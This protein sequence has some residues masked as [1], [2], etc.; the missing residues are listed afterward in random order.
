MIK[1][2][3]ASNGEVSPR[4][5][6]ARGNVCL[7]ATATHTEASWCRVSEDVLTFLQL[8]SVLKT[9][10]FKKCFPQDPRSFFWEQGTDYKLKHNL[11]L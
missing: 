4:H 9:V 6:E 3:A 2:V 11:S 5:R 1:W 8:S 7:P 10:K